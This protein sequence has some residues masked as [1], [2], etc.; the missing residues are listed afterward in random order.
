MTYT[1]EAFRGQGLAKRVV[2]QLCKKLLEL[3]DPKLR[4]STGDNH[5]TPWTP[6]CYI[7]AGTPQ[8][9]HCQCTS[10]NS[11]LH[12]LATPVLFWYLTYVS[13]RK[14]YSPAASSLAVS[15]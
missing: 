4:C 2:V 11:F 15:R 14:W 3:Q 12:R 13:T 10:S 5:S 7:D 9:S 6:Y 1:A 8:Q